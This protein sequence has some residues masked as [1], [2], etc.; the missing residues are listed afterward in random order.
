MA[1]ALA[2]VLLLAACGSAADNESLELVPE[3]ATL[4]VDIQVADILEKVD[5]DSLLD[6]LP[7]EGDAPQTI[8]EALDLIVS[9]TG[10]DLRDITQAIIFGDLQR[11]DNYFGLIVRGAID[12]E[13]LVAAIQRATGAP[14]FTET[15]KGRELHVF[16]GESDG[17]I[18]FTSLDQESLVLGSSDA[19][20]HVVD[21]DAGDRD[22]AEGATYDAFN[23]LPAGLIRL[24]LVVPPGAVQDLGGE[25]AGFLGQQDNLGGLPINADSFDDLEILGFALG[26][27]GDNLKFQV[28][29]DFVGR[30]SAA[31]VGDLLEGLLKVAGALA[32]EGQDLG[33]L[34]RVQ[35]DREGSRL[36]I[37][38]DLQLS[39]IED[40]LEGL[41]NIAS[42]GSFRDATPS[43]I[44]S[45]ELESLQIALDSLMADN[46]LIQVMTP[47]TAVNDFSGLDLDAGA[48]EVFIN[49]YLRNTT[50]TFYYCWSGEGRVMLQ[51]DSPG[52]CPV[53]PIR[54]SRNTGPGE[55]VAIMPTVNHV[56]EG[57]AVAYSTNPPTSGEHWG[58]WADCGFYEGGLPDELIVHNLEHGN[59]VVSYNLSNERDIAALRSA[60]NTFAWDEDWGV[61]RFYDKIPESMVVVAAWG[62]MV[63]MPVFGLDGMA[64]FFAAYAGVLGPERIAC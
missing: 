3:G 33:F 59:I 56:A 36:T 37:S 31:N 38:L 5:L 14:L 60:L 34:D 8:D 10:I 21:V 29:L 40:L 55:E 24:A 62:R 27:D 22:R 23:D 7:D 35:V 39:E 13:G 42:E 50:T 20:R 47:A 15:Y 18:A 32:P 9:Q 11:E 61:I 51:A 16:G 25:I 49:I 63:R 44:Q 43:P 54:Q 41:L 26:Q 28:Q 2:G 57:R 64:P 45:A 4:I 48:G 58:R 6:A 17:F 12:E 1:L 19:V 30:E 46:S 52:Q 53:T